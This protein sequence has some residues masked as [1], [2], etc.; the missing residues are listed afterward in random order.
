[1]AEF[2]ELGLGDPV[3]ISAAH[4]EGVRHLMDLVLADY[5]SKADAPG[6]KG[7]KHPRVSIVEIGRAHV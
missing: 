4:G 6:P 1:M 3:A 5:E 7:P 2:H